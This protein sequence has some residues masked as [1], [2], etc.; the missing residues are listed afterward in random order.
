MSLESFVPKGQQGLLLRSPTT[1]CYTTPA[2]HTKSLLYSR[3][4]RP[5]LSQEEAKLL[6]EEGVPERMGFF[7]RHNPKDTLKKY[8]FPYYN[9]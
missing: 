4:V 3:N 6:D 9:F 5:S 1:Q 2:Y 7:T 8:T